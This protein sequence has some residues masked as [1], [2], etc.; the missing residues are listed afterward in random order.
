MYEEQGKTDSRQ[1]S[2]GCGLSFHRS[3][4]ELCDSRRSAEGDS[5]DSK[6]AKASTISFSLVTK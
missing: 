5:V 6:E 1:N 2:L 3:A 4:V